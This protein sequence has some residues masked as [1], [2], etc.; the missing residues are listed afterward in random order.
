MNN[1]KVTH[2]NTHIYICSKRTLFLSLQTNW[3]FV[4]LLLLMWLWSSPCLVSL[5]NNTYVRWWEN[6]SE[7]SHQ[8][9][10]RPVVDYFRGAPRKIDAA[11]RNKDGIYYF[12][13][14]QRWVT[15]TLLVI[16]LLCAKW[17]PCLTRSAIVPDDATQ[18]SILR[19]T[20]VTH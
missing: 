16:F 7:R 1:L 17:H 14:G 2:T 5:Q 18:C 6:M 10:P 19:V 8:A 4:W 11:L 9:R 12:F 20:N 3:Y 15:V 13:N